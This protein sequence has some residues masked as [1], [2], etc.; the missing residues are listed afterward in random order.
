MPD[1]RVSDAASERR[2]ESK[3]WLSAAGNK[4]N[5]RAKPESE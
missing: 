4:R 1:F 2:L 3:G 5:A